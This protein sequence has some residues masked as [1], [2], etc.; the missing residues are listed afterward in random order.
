MKMMILS[1]LLVLFWGCHNMDEP[2]A[3][4]SGSIRISIG[5]N[6]NKA[7]GMEDSTTASSNT[8]LY[9][10]LIYNETTVISALLDLSNSTTTLSVEVGNYTVLILAGNC[11]GSEGILLGSG[12]QESVAVTED[13]LTDVSVALTSISHEFTVPES[14]SCTETYTIS[15]AGN[16]NNPLLQV[17]SGGTIM[18]NKP[19]IEIGDDATNRYLSCS[20]SGSSWSGT[21]DLNAPILSD[22]TNIQLYGSNIKI[23]DP[24]FGLDSDLKIFGSINWKWINSSLIPE[25]IRMESDKNIEFTSANTG[26]NIEIIWS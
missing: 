12:F 17:S 25:G 22:Q 2:E 18:E 19:Y 7:I 21:I 6:N 3:S 20:H 5:N 26:L 1:I 11:S 13:C 10:V 14:V 16:T 15:V 4:P 9:E 23:V 24:Q 8:D